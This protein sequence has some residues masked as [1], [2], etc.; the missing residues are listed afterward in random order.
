MS[1]R[2]R[3]AVAEIASA[4]YESGRQMKQNSDAEVSISRRA[5]QSPMLARR[6]AI[7]DEALAS[8]MARGAFL[9]Y[10]IPE[11]AHFRRAV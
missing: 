9:Y 6:D 3:Q 1:A 4:S 5:W 8:T 10:E 7:S 11:C 2:S